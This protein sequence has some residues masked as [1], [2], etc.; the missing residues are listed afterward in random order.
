MNVL[1]LGSGGREHSICDNLKKSKKILKLWCIPGNAGIKEIAKYSR[2]NLEDNKQIIT[3]CIKNKIDLV[4]PGSEEYLERGI[5]DAL[6]LNGINVF[7]PSKKSSL[8]ES[9]KIFTKYI[10]KLGNIKTA[11]WEILNSYKEAKK[12]SG[13]LNF[14]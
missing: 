13:F 11:K 7:G 4:I 9:S 1:V 8:L 10:C 14:H 2:L 6:R 3:F 12:S 5:S